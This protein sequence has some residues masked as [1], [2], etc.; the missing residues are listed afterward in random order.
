MNETIIDYVV[1]VVCRLYWIA[2]TVVLFFFFCFHPDRNKTKTKKNPICN[3]CLNE[4][5]IE[6]NDDDDDDD[7]NKT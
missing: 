7:E 6:N 4:I 3:Y 1:V 5:K 2:I